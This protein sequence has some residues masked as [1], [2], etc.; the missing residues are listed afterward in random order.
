MK[1]NLLAILGTVV[2]IT[3]FT[4]SIIYFKKNSSPEKQVQKLECGSPE[5]NDCILQK[6]N[7][8][9]ASGTL[10]ISWEKLP[11]TIENL[12]ANTW[13]SKAESMAKDELQLT[14]YP[15][16]GKHYLLGKHDFSTTISINKSNKKFSRLSC[17]QKSAFNEGVESPDKVYQNGIFDV[18]LK[19]KVNYFYNGGPGS[20]PNPYTP[21]VVELL[22]KIHIKI[23]NC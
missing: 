6:L 13:Y 20:N 16:I 23:G 21:E 8:P 11:I 10:K 19:H 22:K 1:K 12:P 17:I 18:A 5:S 2:I 3:I 7:L 9:T 4:G 15:D 14:I